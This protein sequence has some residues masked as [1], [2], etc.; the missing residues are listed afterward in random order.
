MKTIILRKLKIPKNEYGSK[1]NEISNK[2][3]MMM[4]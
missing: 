3:L 1:L 2:C 4:D